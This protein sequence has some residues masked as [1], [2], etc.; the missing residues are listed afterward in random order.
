MLYLR[1]GFRN[2]NLQYERVRKTLQRSKN[3]EYPK[4]PRSIEEIKEAFRQPD[5][6]EKYGLTLDG[7]N[8]FYVDTVISV[9]YAFTVFASH[10]VIDFVKANIRPNLRHFLM[11]GTFDSLPN[12]FYQLLIIAIEYQNKVSAN[13]HFYLLGV[14]TY[15]QYRTVYDP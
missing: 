11:D 5:I 14:S 8:Y 13:N 9:D 12:K 1:D 3:E 15:L 6:K 2:T 4:I 10:F 7:D